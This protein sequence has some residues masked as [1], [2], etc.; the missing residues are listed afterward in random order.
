MALL[1]GQSDGHIATILIQHERPVSLG[2]ETAPESRFEPLHSRGGSPESKRTPKKKGT[3]DTHV[4]AI[5]GDAAVPQHGVGVIRT[6]VECDVSIFD[7]PASA[8]HELSLSVVVRTNTVAGRGS[9]A[10]RSPEGRRAPPQQGEA[11]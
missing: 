2:V 8:L 7:E 1:G 3:L 11:A 10:S 6:V 5:V 4:T 9:A